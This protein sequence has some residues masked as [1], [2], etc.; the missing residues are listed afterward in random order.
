M[1]EKRS[2]SEI[3]Q[4]VSRDDN[5]SLS[6]RKQCEILD[7]N[8]SSVYRHPKGESTENLEIMKEMDRHHTDHPDEGVIGMRGML[9]ALGY[10]VN[11][12]RIRRLMRLMNIKAIYPQ[13]NLTKLAKGEYVYPYLLRNMDITHINQVWSIDISYIAMEHGF[14]YLTAII[15]VYS[16]FVVGWHIGNSLDA[17]VS[18]G[19][20][21][22]CISRW[23]APEIVNSDQGCQ[24]TSKDWVNTLKDNSIQISM[25][26]KGRA[27]DNIWIERFW[28]T[29]KRGYVYL[30]PVE[31]GLELYNGLKGFIDYYNMERSHACLGGV[32]PS[33]VYLDKKDKK[34]VKKRKKKNKYA[35]A[36]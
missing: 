1:Q 10:I 20:L 28:R 25:D 4:L 16:R 3:R 36:A 34:I 15:D 19:L 22:N 24:Y 31:N 5:T 27:T 23:G 26:G 18:V 7:I 35:S 17:D 13:K 14:M 29:V 8:R 6:V 33:S 30:H 2:K 21:K 12:K 11:P 32:S 9:F